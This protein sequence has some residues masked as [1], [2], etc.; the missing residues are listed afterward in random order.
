MSSGLSS[1]LPAGRKKLIDP[2]FVSVYLSFN[3]NRK[4]ADK[5]GYLYLTMNP[6]V[7]CPA[8]NE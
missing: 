8:K 1:G 7:W 6:V 2:A 3:G 5:H 4:T